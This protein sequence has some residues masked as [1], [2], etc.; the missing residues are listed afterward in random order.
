MKK[1]DL[2]ATLNKIEGD[3]DIV[4]WVGYVDDWAHFELVQSRLSRYNQ[5]VRIRQIC[6]ERD[7]PVLDEVKAYDEA[8]CEEG[9]RHGVRHGVGLHEHKDVIIINPLPRGK[10]HHARLGSVTY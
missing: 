3:P 8:H 9:W 10:E 7:N 6:R 5:G 4:M 2:I 1:S